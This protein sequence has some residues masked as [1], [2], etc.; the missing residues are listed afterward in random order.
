MIYSIK[1][2]LKLIEKNKIIIS[3]N[4]IEYILIITLYTYKNIISTY[5][6]N[7]F[8]KIYTYINIIKDKFIN[9]YGFI[10]EYE[11]ELFIVLLSVSKIGPSTCISILSDIPFNELKQLILQE[12]VKKISNIKGIGIKSAQR[13][14][15]ELKEKIKKVSLYH[16]NITIDSLPIIDESMKALMSLG[17][18]KNIAETVLKDIVN[19]FPNNN[20][21]E[22]IIKEALKKI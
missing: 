2:I 14:V 8:I 11:K 10:N 22:F 13:I 3:N 16:G 9:L 20:N 6:I 19:K 4:N 12:N 7:D 5:K 18:N 21:I 17:V 15:I 1:G